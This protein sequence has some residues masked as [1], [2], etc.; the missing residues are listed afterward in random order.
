MKAADLEQEIDLGLGYTAR[1]TTM[2][3]DESGELASVIV[4][5]PAG[6]HCKYV[7]V[8]AARLEGR[9][10]GGVSIAPRANA[11]GASWRVTNEQPLSLQ[12][13]IRCACDVEH[14]GKGQHG[15]I[16]LGRWVN[17]NGITA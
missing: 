4:E 3:G 8:G 17:A 15:F 1:P 16:T 13:S 5:G 6:E 10:A 7:G 9:C 14:P 12:P 2:Y 11:N